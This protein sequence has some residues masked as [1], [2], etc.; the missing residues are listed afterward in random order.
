[1]WTSSSRFSVFI[2]KRIVVEV[3]QVSI[4]VFLSHNPHS[5]STE[6]NSKHCLPSTKITIGFILSWSIVELFTDES[7]ILYAVSVMFKLPKCNK[8]IN[9]T[10]RN[11]SRIFCRHRLNDSS[12]FALT[13][14][15]PVLNSFISSC[16]KEMYTNYC[17]QHME[18]KGNI[19]LEI[20]I[21]FALCRTF[22]ISQYNLTNVQH[23]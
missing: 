10:Y 4:D 23:E 22:K 15:L 2:H 7:L 17:W 11:F 20:Q 19:M 12:T 14:T 21:K 3:A 8:N 1:M 16:R 6:K 18:K 5:Q 9:I 13:Y